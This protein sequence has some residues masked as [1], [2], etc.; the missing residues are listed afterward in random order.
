MT[1]QTE[2][3]DQQKMTAFLQAN[4]DFLRDFLMQHPEWLSRSAD[5]GNLPATTDLPKGDNIVN[6]TQHIAVRARAEARKL[7]ATNQSL[8]DLAATNMLHWH[9]L[10]HATLGF[11]ACLDLVSFA[12]MIDEEL[13]VIFGL[14]GAR[15][16]MPEETALPQAEELGFLV[17]PEAQIAALLE[18]KSIYLGPNHKQIELF[19][20]PAASMAVVALPDQL[21]APIAG[22]ALLLGGRNAEHFHPEQGQTLLTYL[23]EIAGVCLLARLEG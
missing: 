17:L 3:F 20:T 4:P 21:P 23:A 15:L 7:Q 22:S 14:S 10:H 12:Q 2:I 11:L 16:I 5:A 1:K 19:N 18:A 6:L 13:P 8:L 9:Q